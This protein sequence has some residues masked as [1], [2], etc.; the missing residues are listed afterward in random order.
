MTCLQVSS[1]VAALVLREFVKSLYTK[2]NTLLYC[3]SLT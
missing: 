1:F 2:A 3:G